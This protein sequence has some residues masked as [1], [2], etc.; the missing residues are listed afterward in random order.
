MVGV[1]VRAGRVIGGE[2]VMFAEAVSTRPP[3]ENTW[4]TPLSPTFGGCGSR[5][6]TAAA[7]TSG[8]SIVVRA[9]TERGQPRRSA[10][11]GVQPVAGAAHGLQRR[12]VERLVDP[13]PQLAHVDLDDVGV[14]LE[15]E[16]PDV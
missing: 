1:A 6:A 12:P 8:G 5:P 10:T 11:V 14:T 4:A 9:R 15:R 7:D 16:V 3:S 13:Q 2:P